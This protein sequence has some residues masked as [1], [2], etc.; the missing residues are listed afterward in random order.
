[1]RERDVGI[2]GG[3]GRGGWLGSRIVCGH[4]GGGLR[5]GVGTVVGGWLN[6]GNNRV[7]IIIILIIRENLER[8]G[9]PCRMLVHDGQLSDSV[10]CHDGVRRRG[11]PRRCCNCHPWRCGRHHPWRCRI[12]GWGIDLARHS[13]G[14]LMNGINM[15]QRGSGRSWD[16]MS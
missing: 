12:G 11:H 2:T 13:G 14:E 1:M 8:V 15:F 10:W 4:S 9:V 3:R 5:T 7:G 16:C 6:A